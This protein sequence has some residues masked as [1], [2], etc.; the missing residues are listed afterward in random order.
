[1]IGGR[2]A[3]ELWGLRRLGRQQVDAEDDCLGCHRT[4]RYWWKHAGGEVL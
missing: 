4:N 2:S 1:M 3:K